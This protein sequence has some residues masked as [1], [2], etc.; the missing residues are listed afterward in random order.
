MAERRRKPYPPHLGVVAAAAGVFG[1]EGWQ[2]AGFGLA[3]VGIAFV[4][5]E[6]VSA[7]DVFVL[8]GGVGGVPVVA[9]EFL[10]GAG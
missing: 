2:P 5:E 6:D 10:V 7:P 3:E 4:A 8:V 9:G 1:R